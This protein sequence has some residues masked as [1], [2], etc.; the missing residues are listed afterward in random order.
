[1]KRAIFFLLCSAVTALGQVSS[2]QVDPTGKVIG[3]KIINYITGTSTLQVD[4]VPITPGGGSLPGGSNGNF[5]FNSS[6]SFGGSAML[7]YNAGEVDANTLGFRVVDST[8]P[9]K[10]LSFDLSN[11]PTASNPS[12]LIPN[13]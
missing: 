3:P 8:D 9:T 11:L 5:Q 10:K 12:L 13:S 1:M 6:G 2:V 7:T 4:G